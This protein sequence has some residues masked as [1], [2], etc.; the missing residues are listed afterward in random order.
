[1]DIIYLSRLSRIHEEHIDDIFLVPDGRL[2]FVRLL[3]SRFRYH[4]LLCVS[5]G[6]W[7]EVSASVLRS[8]CLPSSSRVLVSLAVLLSSPFCIRICL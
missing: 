4:T 1:M 5:W 8:S 7:Q 2:L 6:G 3:D